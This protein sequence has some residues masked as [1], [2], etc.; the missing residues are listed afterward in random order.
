MPNARQTGN[1]FA[2]AFT[3]IVIK[4]REFHTF[5]ERPVLPLLTEKLE[6]CRKGMA[7]KTH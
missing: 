2:C 4:L 5:P 3:G 6:A 1:K 7:E